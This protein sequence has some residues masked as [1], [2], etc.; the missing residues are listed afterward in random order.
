MSFSWIGGKDEFRSYRFFCNILHSEEFLLCAHV[1]THIFHVVL[2]AVLGEV[3]RG[4][5]GVVVTCS[6]D[7]RALEILL[8]YSEFVAHFRAQVD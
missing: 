6:F 2:Y 3:C 7:V 4:V 1:G 5:T 8:I